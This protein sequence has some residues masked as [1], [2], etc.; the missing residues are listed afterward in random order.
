MV[1]LIIRSVGVGLRLL[2]QKRYGKLMD[3]STEYFPLQTFTID[4]RNHQ[5]CCASLCVAC[6]VAVAVAV[7]SSRARR[8]GFLSRATL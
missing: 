1:L 6:A 2:E 4:G 5:G 3:W 7:A 8:Q